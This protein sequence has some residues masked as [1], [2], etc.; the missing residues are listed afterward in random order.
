MGVEG[1]FDCSAPHIFVV[2]PLHPFRATSSP[3]VSISSSR[4][5]SSLLALAE[6]RFRDRRW[7]AGFVAGYTRQHIYLLHVGRNIVRFRDMCL[8]VMTGWQLEWLHV[9]INDLL[10]ILREGVGRNAF[11]LKIIHIEYPNCS[12][13]LFRFTLET[14]SEFSLLLWMGIGE[15]GK[16]ERYKPAMIFRIISPST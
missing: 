15:A 3:V 10:M 6:R 11:N 7:C 8:S 4:R 12:L 5:I 9:V 16:R 1:I 14:F 13:F 2:P